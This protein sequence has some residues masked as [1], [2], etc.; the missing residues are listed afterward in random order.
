MR[1]RRFAEVTAVAAARAV[2]V[3]VGALAFWAAAP[4]LIGWQPTS[5]MTA[6]MAPAI[7]VGDVVVA[8]PVGAD[9]LVAGRVLLSDDPDRP[10]R[11]RL[12]RLDEVTAD[13]TLRTKGDANPEPD[14]SPLH[15]DAVHGVGVLRVPWV[16]LP[17]VWARTGDAMPLALTVIGVGIVGMLASRRGTDPDDDDDA[18]TPAVDT[19][20]DAPPMTRRSRRALGLTAIAAVGASLSATPAWASFGDQSSASASISAARVDPPFA[21]GCAW[22]STLVTWRYEGVAPRSFDLLVDGQ[23][24]I[25]GISPGDRS[26]RLPSSRVYLPGQ[27]STVQIR[28]V[29]SDNWSADSWESVSIG[30]V[31]LGI[32]APVCR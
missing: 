5:V 16:G 23:V 10:G 14:S 29:V 19:V 2:L 6:S 26:A 31:F 30:G 11:L 24:A 13:G 32:G 12:H 18:S 8:R 4:A 3:F 17:V 1:A 15:P 7:A 25:S 22:G 27:R 28:A 20:A 21:L 9:Q